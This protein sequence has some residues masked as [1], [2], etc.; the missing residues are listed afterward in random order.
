M[1][2]DLF[3][4][5]EL[6]DIV[7]HYYDWLRMLEYSYGR[8]DIEEDDIAY[9]KKQ[10]DTYKAVMPRV[11]PAFKELQNDLKQAVQLL[12]DFR[13][14]Y[15]FYVTQEKL[16][17]NH[18]HPIWGDI[19]RLLEKYG[20]NEIEMGHGR[21]KYITEPHFKSMKHHANFADVEDDDS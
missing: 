10:I 2:K 15:Q 1:K 12:H 4:D 8:C 9:F 17:A 7:T 6:H 3:D 11:R 18:H 13:V 16:G 5:G 19:A 21:W 20:C 14:F